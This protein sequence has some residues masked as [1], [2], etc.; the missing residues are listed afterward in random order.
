[1]GGSQK[2]DSK[3]EEKKEAAIQEISPFK[4]SIADTNGGRG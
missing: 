2:K 3:K 1:M 4:R